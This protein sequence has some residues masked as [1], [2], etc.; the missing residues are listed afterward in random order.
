MLSLASPTEA[1]EIVRRLRMREDITSILNAIKLGAPLQ[2][3]KGGEPET[4]QGIEAEYSQKEQTFGQVQGSTRHFAEVTS[5]SQ[6]QST[7]LTP[8]TGMQSWTTVTEDA[9]FIN[10]LLALYFCWQHPFFQTFSEHSFREDMAAGRTRFC[11][12][13]LVNSVCAAGSLFSDQPE[14]RQKTL[15]FFDEA[16]RLLHQIEGPSVTSVAATYLLCHVEGARGRLSA[17][18]NYSGQSGRMALDMNLHLRNDRAADTDA[19][20]K[21]EER[22]RSHAFWGCFVADQ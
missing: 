9:A 17:L 20:A 7:S 19:S 8:A 10:H 6:H 13:L 21:G 12:S 11:S 18:W 16:V 2:P 1:E 22:A 4:A 5:S 15:E 14:A 3:L